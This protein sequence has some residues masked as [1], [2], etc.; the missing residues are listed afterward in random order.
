MGLERRRGVKRGIQ[1]EE[2]EGTS[3]HDMEGVMGS[4]WRIK[5]NDYE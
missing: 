3:V 5:G 2:L 4:F 1:L